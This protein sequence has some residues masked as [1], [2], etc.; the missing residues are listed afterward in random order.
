M[1]TTSVQDYQIAALAAGFT[2]GFGF[3][4]VWEAV[5]QTRRNRNPSRSAYIYM[6]WGEI[7]VNVIIAIFAW[8]FL[9]G[10]LGP[11]T[12]TKLKWGTV[13]FITS[14]NI[15]VFIIWIPA[16][17]VP[18]VSQTFVKINNVW[19]KIS[20]VL[21]LLVDAGLNW[22]FLKTV[23]ERLVKQH[24]LTKY[25]P[26]VGFNAKLMVISLAMDALVIGLMFLNNQVVYI[27]FH[28]VVYIVKLN[29]EMS[30]AS[31]VVRLAQG[32]PEN[33][34]YLK[35]KFQDSSIKSRSELHSGQHTHIQSVQ[36]KSK[37]GGNNVLGAND[38]NESPGG[39]HCQTDLNVVSELALH[40]MFADDIPL[41]KKTAHLH[42]H[43]VGFL[44]VKALPDIQGRMI[45]ATERSLPFASNAPEASAPISFESRIALALQGN[46]WQELQNINHA[47]AVEKEILDDDEDDEV[48][49]PDAPEAACEDD[50][51]KPPEMSAKQKRKKKKFTRA[52]NRDTGDVLHTIDFASLVPVATTVTWDGDP[53]LL[54]SYNWQASTDNTNTIFVPGEPAKWNPPP[55]PRTLDPDS[56]FEYSDYNYA[57]QPRT[58]YEPMFQALSL[59]NPSYQFTDIDVLADRNNL[60]VLLEF[61][62]GKSNG[63]F[64]L[65][66]YS[67]FNTLVIVRNES[68][69]WQFS[70][71][72]SHGCNFERLFTTP[73]KGMEDATS[74]YRAIRYPMGPLNVVCRFE[75][76]A[77]DDG[78]EAAD[79]SASE[80]QAVCGGLAAR[81]VFNYGAPIRVLQKGH[82]V[83]TS[84]IVE[85][86]TQTH[87]AE[88]KA[89]TCQDQL[90]FGRT[91]LLYTG[92][93]VP[94]TGAVSRIR[95]EDA[96]ARVKVWEDNQQESLRKLAAL[97]GLLRSTLKKINAPNHAAV[98]VREDKA[99]PLTIRSMSGRHRAVGR[100][101]FAT[102]WRMT[103]QGRGGRH[104]RGGHV[105]R[106]REDV[107]GGGQAGFGGR[108]GAR[109]RGGRGQHGP[110]GNGQSDGRGGRGG[111]V[112]GQQSN[113]R[114]GN[115]GDQGRQP[116]Y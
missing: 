49:I 40:S 61:C 72:K 60:R 41:H 64:R 23:K 16:H 80:H 85:L 47:A 104:Q 20:K 101:A 67:I 2:I 102:H 51:N 114:D 74:H 66:L 103:G 19:D 70:D 55:L 62:Q 110:Q 59:M 88:Y 112:R 14:I 26:L 9:N 39:I 12:V 4:T 11:S 71:G 81:P 29:I 50:S 107:R 37:R 63:P 33:D 92:P 45:A 31:L 68:K 69:W 18:P 22:Y 109:Q 58:P 78:V 73:S 77:Y 82:V 48:E 21:I 108:G 13:A 93:Y 34:M 7:I 100:Q 30:M 52:I 8:L 116:T 15:A 87:K 3:L 65:D 75:A 91:S 25:A 84:Q 54:C 97:L 113:G 89:V 27:Q 76:D 5:K 105:P 46:N 24:G 96:R 56:G 94:G 53:E 83:P 6:V 79:L 99:G 28:P 111:H 38:S 42:A 98:L 32:R 115:G 36:M 95:Y 90:W 43:E 57:R 17:M 44:L 106:A 1:V 86:K 35:D 10:K